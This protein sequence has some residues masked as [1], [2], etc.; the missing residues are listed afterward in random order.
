[1]NKFEHAS[2]EGGPQVNKFEQVHSGHMET[3]VDMAS[4]KTE[5]YLPATLLACSK[6][7]INYNADKM[8]RMS[9]ESR[10]NTPKIHKSMRFKSKTRKL[11]NGEMRK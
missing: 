10:T 3:P 7:D 5:N 9:A 4:D 6:K 2:V 1:M 11:P 8:N